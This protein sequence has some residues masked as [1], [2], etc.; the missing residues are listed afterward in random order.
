MDRDAW[1]ARHTDPDR[2]HLVGPNRFLVEIVGDS[3][4]GTAIDLA[5]GRGRNAIWLAEQGW[6]VTAVDWSDGGLGVLRREA[7]SRGLAIQLE[8]ADLAEWQPSLQY[9]LVLIAYLQV[10]RPLRQGVWRKAVDA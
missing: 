1:N 7:A 2:E 4:P 8:Q 10:A 9:G 3:Y 5:A 6:S